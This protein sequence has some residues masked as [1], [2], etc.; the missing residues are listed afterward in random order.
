[1]KSDEDV[2]RSLD[3]IPDF[4]TVFD[5]KTPEQVQAMLDQ[6]LLSEE[7]AE[8]ASTETSK[9]SNSSSSDD[10]VTKA[11]AELLG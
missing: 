6:F 4:T 9:Y 5:R 2:A 11:F 1:M 7:D 10:K 8:D 3:S